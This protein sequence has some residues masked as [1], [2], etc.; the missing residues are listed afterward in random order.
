MKKG[1]MIV[2]RIAPFITLEACRVN[3][4]LTQSELADILNVSVTTIKN[5]EKGNN[6]PPVDKAVMIS[7]ISK[8]PL[9]FIILCPES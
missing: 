6:I 5:W 1:G 4:R 9:D 2:D 8:V 7:R 3:A